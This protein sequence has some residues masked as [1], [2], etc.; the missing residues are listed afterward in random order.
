MK[1]DIRSAF[2][3]KYYADNGDKWGKH[4]FFGERL[5][6]FGA[7]TQHFSRKRTDIIKHTMDCQKI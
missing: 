1:N 7:S 5:C 3:M 6:N 2:Y 4:G